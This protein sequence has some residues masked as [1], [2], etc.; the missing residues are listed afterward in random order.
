MGSFLKE[1]IN[2]LSFPYKLRYNVSPYTNGHTV[3]IGDNDVPYV[4]YLYVHYFLGLFR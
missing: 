3:I 1:S 4:Q 2:S